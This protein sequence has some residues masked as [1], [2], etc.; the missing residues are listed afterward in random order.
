MA[1]LSRCAELR[2]G[3]PSQWRKGLFLVHM[4][5]PV[6]AAPQTLLETQAGEGPSSSEAALTAGGCRAH[7][8]RGE[9]VLKACLFLHVLH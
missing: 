6:G 9:T 4:S 8:Q 1:Y 3:G 2:Q 5:G 7:S